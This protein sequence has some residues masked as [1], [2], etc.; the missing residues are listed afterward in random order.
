[1]VKKSHGYRSRTRALMSKKVR[2]KGLG[3]PSK[4]LIDYEAGQ[5]VDIVIDS[6][7][8]KG[9]PHRRY[10]GRTGIA[11]A[12]RGRAV[13]VDVSLGNAIKTLIIRREH[14]QPSRG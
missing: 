1:M 3:S 7:F 6:G 12:L 11:T 13:V 14:L 9:M 4:V 2:E 10:Q 8:H 5:R